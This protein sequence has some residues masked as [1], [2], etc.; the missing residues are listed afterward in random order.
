MYHIRT[1][2]V[3]Y[4]VLIRAQY[5]SGGT[6]ER[7]PHPNSPQCSPTYCTSAPTSAPAMEVEAVLV[8][9]ASRS[10]S[11]ARGS[12]CLLWV[13]STRFLACK[14]LL[15]RS[16]ARRWHTPLKR[17]REGSMLFDSLRR[18]GASRCRHLHSPSL[19]RTCMRTTTTAMTRKHLR[20]PRREI[21]P[22]WGRNLNSHPTFRY[23]Y[24]TYL[25]TNSNLLT[26]LTGHQQHNYS[27]HAITS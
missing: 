25:L 20:E 13:S 5:C 23:C 27:G 17:C 22:P 14:H 15:D 24:R 18:S 21:L 10:A 26:N 4:D 19:I 6:K 9:L 16:Q 11:S 2:T 12:H 8:G 3:Q 1:S 7:E